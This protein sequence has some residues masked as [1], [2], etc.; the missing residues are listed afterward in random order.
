MSFANSGA[1]QN[2]YRPD[3]RI[4][5][6]IAALT[7]QVAALKARA[8]TLPATSGVSLGSLGAC[9]LLGMRDGRPS[10][11]VDSGQIELTYS[12]GARTEMLMRVTTNASGAFIS[13]YNGA[14]LL[15]GRLASGVLQLNFAVVAPQNLR[16]VAALAGPGSRMGDIL[17]S[18][19]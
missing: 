12:I 5:N 8:D 19:V 11:E 9:G 14:T 13:V 3:T 16:I 2:S 15:G 18:W 10:F 6:A 1:P 17:L 7:T 4:T